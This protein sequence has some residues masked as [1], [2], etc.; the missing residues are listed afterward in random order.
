MQK[1]KIKLVFLLGLFITIFSLLGIS[2][3]AANENVQ[4]I[5]K[6][7]T[8]YLIYVK[9]N[10]DKTFEFALSTAPAVAIAITSTSFSYFAI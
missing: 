2:V 7:D 1:S 6:L 9:D 8:D 4:I 3:Y 10:L 5:K